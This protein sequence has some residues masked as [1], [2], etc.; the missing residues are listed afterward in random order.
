MIRSIF[1]V[2]LHSFVASIF[3]QGQKP[4]KNNVFLKAC[5]V[6][7]QRKKNVTLCHNACLQ[8][9]YN[10]KTREEP[11][12]SDAFREKTPA[13]RLS[14]DILTEPCI[15]PKEKSRIFGNVPCLHH[16]MSQC[17]IMILFFTKTTNRKKT[18]LYSEKTGESYKTREDFRKWRK[19]EWKVIEF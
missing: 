6:L 7:I 17:K 3:R 15:F 11:R 16:N 8:F 4:L 19:D 18:V 9:C 1:V 2:S 14:I 12:F 10:S 5:I 13:S